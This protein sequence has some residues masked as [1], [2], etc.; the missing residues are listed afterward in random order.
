MTI[1]FD[2][3]GVILNSAELKTDC[4]K[5]SVSDFNQSQINKFLDFHIENMGVSR[6]KKFDY[7]I[8]DILSSRKDIDNLK[9]NLLDRFQECLEKNLYASN[10]IY[11]A[12]AILEWAK[13]NNHSCHIISGT[14][15]NDLIEIVKH[16]KI[17][18]YFKSINGTPG[19][20]AFHIKKLSSLFKIKLDDS[21]F[22]GDAITDFD[23]AAQFNIKFFAIDCIHMHNFWLDNKVNVFDNLNQLK[24]HLE[25]NFN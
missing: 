7:F 12:K 9:K 2:F 23:A 14:P 17:E 19:N 21:V 10:L 15:E 22:V 13:K 4:F 18:H 20:K 16:Y 25:K 1:F 3:D 8:Q 24:I 11:G 6:H 5:Y